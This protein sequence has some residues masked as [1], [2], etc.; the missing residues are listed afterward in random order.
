MK[1]PGFTVGVTGGIGSG[2]SA[3]CEILREF[4]R[5][6]IA[7]DPLARDIM[8]TDV[9]VI[10]R[11]KE[12][13][14]ETIYSSDRDLNRGRMAS[15]I[16]GDSLL[17]AKVNEIVH[18]RVFESI[19]GRLSSLPETRRV[20]YVVVEAALIY[21]SGMDKLLD[22]VV[23]VDA[24]VETRLQRVMIRDGLTREE[25]TKRIRAQMSADE[26]IRRGDFVIRNNQDRMSLVGKIRLVDTILDSLSQQT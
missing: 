26:K 14:G 16:F 8:E 13:L 23:V 7:A 12:L 6:V 2:K 19:R 4:G 22:L 18:P 10:H 15:M 3:V 11:L 20:P 25:V 24:D 5:E 9:R 1:F 17:R 21:E